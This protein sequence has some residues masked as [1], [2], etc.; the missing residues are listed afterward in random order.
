VLSVLHTADRI[1][2]ASVELFVTCT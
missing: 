2:F 1:A